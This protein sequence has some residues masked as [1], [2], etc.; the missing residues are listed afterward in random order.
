[1][2]LDLCKGSL[3]RPNLREMMWIRTVDAM[4]WILKCGIGD[5]EFN[6][7]KEDEIP[8]LCRFC[9]DFI[10]EDAQTE[11]DRTVMI[12]L[13]KYDSFKTG[14]FG[15]FANAPIVRGGNALASI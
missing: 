13:N 4:E 7:E 1:M 3:I 10:G 14:R 6:Q 9:N 11:D 12:V 5:M 15:N 2:H 8:I